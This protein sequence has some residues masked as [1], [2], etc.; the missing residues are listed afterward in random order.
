MRR[1]KLLPAGTTKHFS[2]GSA[3]QVESPAL[4]SPFRLGNQNQWECSY[5]MPVSTKSVKEN[6]YLDRVLM[7]NTCCRAPLRLLDTHT[8]TSNFK[9][10]KR[11]KKS[12]VPQKT[13]VLE[14]LAGDAGEDKKL[15]DIELTEKMAALSE[16]AAK[17]AQGK[18]INS[19]I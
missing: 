13:A 8:H 2:G 7:W 9:E 6:R 16:Q 18:T 14:R 12:L 15:L 10:T 5:K 1:H 19:T 4:T 17:Q 3:K 11:N